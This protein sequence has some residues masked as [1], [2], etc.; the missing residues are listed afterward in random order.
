M[1]RLLILSIALIVLGLLANDLGFIQRL[2]SYGSFDV[3]G[4][5]S[6][7]NLLSPGVQDLAS[8][9]IY[10]FDEIERRPLIIIIGII[11]PLLLILLLIRN[12][13]LRLGI[14]RW[15]VQ[16]IAFIITRL[17][18]LRVS[19]L[20]PVQRTSFGVFQFLNCQACEMATGSCPIGSIQAFLCNLRFP[21]FI[22]GFL[23]ILGLALGRWICGWLCPFGLLSDILHKISLKI[24]LPLKFSMGKYI[25]LVLLP[26]IALAFFGKDHLPFC[27][28]L[29]HSGLV[30]GLLPYYL[31]TAK[32]AFNEG[33]SNPILLYHIGLGIIFLL[34]VLLFSGRFFCRILCPLGGFLGLFNK[35][36]LV[37]VVHN[38]ENCKGCEKCRINC[39]MAV[40]LRRDNFL[41]WTNCIMCSR[42][43]KLC[44]HKARRWK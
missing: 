25:V 17:G 43:I 24:K 14:K 28:Y 33:L 26:I 40:D 32:P 13:E 34:F 22:L 39:P 15:L 16:W 7:V 18:V 9:K 35:I 20:C 11:F 37:R 31:T 38:K 30:Y 27:T 29:C 3:P 4:G 36:S 41:D 5:K 42:C 12:I 19:G 2:N 10:R 23:L 1:K 21:F 44:P 8:K 6:F